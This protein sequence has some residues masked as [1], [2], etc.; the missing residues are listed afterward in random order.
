M[1]RRNFLTATVAGVLTAMPTAS[2]LAQQDHQRQNAIPVGD[3]RLEAKLRF[4]SQL[5][6]WIPGKTDVEKMA[7]LK[8]WGFEAVEVGR[9]A[10]DKPHEVKKKADDAG[11]KVSVITG[12]V[13][14]GKTC[15]ADPKEAQ[16]GRD[17]LKKSLE[18]AAILECN[19]VV[20]VPARRF[21]QTTREIRATLIDIDIKTR[22]IKGGFLKEMGDFAASLNVNII[23]E[24]LH[25]G[26]TAFLHQVAEA[27]SICRD[28]QSEGVKTLGDF[29]HMYYEEVCDMAAFI[30]GGQYV[31]HVHFGAGNQRVL[32]GQIQD[33]SFIAGFRGLKY[34]GYNDFMSFECGCLGGNDKGDIEVPKTLEFLKQS[35]EEA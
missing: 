9:D 25:R 8:K 6:G 29:F 20:F 31:K 13:G 33:H 5:R 28:S 10:I 26:E 16:E 19:G 15:S 7:Q 3:K 32:P 24:P 18:S 22:Q 30:A 2:S 14:D 11:L 23:F 4:S 17:H 1:Q 12:G 34:I 21:T 35:W 27:A